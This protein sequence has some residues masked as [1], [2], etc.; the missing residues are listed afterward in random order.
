MRMYTGYDDRLG[1]P[2]FTTDIVK[3]RCPGFSLSGK[4]VV[5]QVDENT[6]A[7]KDNRTENECKKENVGR[8][9]PFYDDAIYTIL[10]TF[11]MDAK[12]GE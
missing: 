9:Y 1:N 7:I 11:P 8:V 2:I 3:F 5:F 12:K 10:K 4:G 6:F